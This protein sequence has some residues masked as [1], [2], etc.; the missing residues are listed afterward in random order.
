[1]AT[2]HELLYQSETFSNLNFAEAIKQVAHNVLENAQRDIDIDIS[3]DIPSLNLN[4]NQALPTALVINE[5][6]SNIAKHAFKDRREGNIDISIRERNDEITLK[7]MDDGRE[8]PDEFY[9][10][11]HHS[12]GMEL[13]NTLT[14]QL[15]GDYTYK[16]ND[17]QTIFEL[18]FMKR[19]TKGAGNASL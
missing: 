7:V 15:E 12:M 16:R 17:D 9:P 10:H 3:F 2:I 6:V 11:Q 8:L 5:V 4:I 18:R 13:I 14:Q 1:M 19:D